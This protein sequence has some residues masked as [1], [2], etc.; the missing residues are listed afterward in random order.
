MYPVYPVYPY[1]RD[2]QKPGIHVGSQ[3]IPTNDTNPKTPNATNG[4]QKTA[5]SEAPC[6]FQP[7]QHTDKPKKSSQVNSQR[8]TESVADKEKGTVAIRR[9]SLPRAA[10][11]PIRVA[12]PHAKEDSI[13]SALAIEPFYTVE[14]AA[15]LLRLARTE[16]FHEIRRGRLRSIKRGRSRRIPAEW[17]NEYRS[18]LIQEGLEEVA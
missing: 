4:V 7:Y 18:L 14:E 6:V 15:D 11:N 1:R 5:R 10:Q 9:A 13:M 17:L 2:L 8:A 12:T 16:L 3:C